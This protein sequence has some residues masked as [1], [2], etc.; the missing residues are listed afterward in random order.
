MKIQNS[1]TW[2]V[3]FGIGLSSLL[4]QGCSSHTETTNKEN[5]QQSQTLTIGF[6]KSSLSSIV[7]QTEQNLLKKEF[8]QV[9][10]QWREFPAGPQ[11]L[12]ALS[13]GAIDIG[14]VGNTPPIFAQAGNKNIV[15]VGYENVQP[16]WQA[17]VVS[18]NSTIQN[19]EQLKGKKVAVQKGS[20]AHDLLGRVLEKAHLKWSD[21]QP[22]W[23]APADAR[24]ALDKGSVDAWVIWEPF[25]TVAE[26]E[27]NARPIIDGT[28]FEN[29]YNF[30]ISRPDFVKNHASEVKSFIQASN[31]AAQ[32][33]VA[34][35][36]ETRSLYQ[37]AINVNADIAQRVLDKRYKP[38]LMKPMTNEVIA[39]QQQIADRFTT[40]QV[41]PQH[42]D[43]KQAVWQ[44]Q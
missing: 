19:I 25:L 24:A 17:V 32:W 15:Y 33:I 36:T 2:N 3:L 41:I 6:Q 21:I 39:A 4:L 18:A 10:V 9:N 28:Q 38:S 11:M 43:V 22:V 16:Q 26:V 44:G 30:L 34:H 23:L 14:S 35:P 27:G 42:I 12:E 8:P 13:A 40:D 29:T 31:E 37:N 1:Y 20:S 5:T 7:L